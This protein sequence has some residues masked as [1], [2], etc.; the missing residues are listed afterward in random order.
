MR[1]AIAIGGSAG[2]FKVVVELLTK[3]PKS[4]NIPIFLCLHRLKH[5]RNGFSEALSLR[6]NLKV[7]EPQDKDEILPGKIYL[8]PA[9][10]HLLVGLDGKFHLSVEEAVNHSRPSIDYLFSSAALHYGKYLTGVLLSGANRD[11]AIGMQ[12]IN[13]EGGQTIVQSPEESQVN[14]MPKSCLE[15]FKP[16]L[17]LESEQ[18]INYLVGLK[19]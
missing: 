18:I 19:G 10:Y 15:L 2:S 16:D 11:G 9:N 3:I 8:A 6:S 7:V 5:V 12:H 1:N 17:I 13:M 4:Y 14:T